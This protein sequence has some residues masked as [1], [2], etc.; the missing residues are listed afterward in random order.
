MQEQPKK[1]QRLLNPKK[2]NLYSKLYSKLQSKDIHKMQ[3]Y[4]NYL[5]KKRD[6][7]WNSHY[8]K[9]SI[10]TCVLYLTVVDPLD[11]KKNLI[12]TDRQNFPSEST[13]ELYESLFKS[14][15]NYNN[16]N[17]S[18]EL[19]LF[20]EDIEEKLFRHKSLFLLKKI[21]K[22]CDLKKERENIVWKLDQ[23]KKAKEEIEQA[24]SYLIG[25]FPLKIGKLS[26]FIKNCEVYI[27]AVNDR[28][29]KI[30]PSLEMLKQ[31]IKISMKIERLKIYIMIA[32]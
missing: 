24:K 29:N 9:E 14:D 7:L 27:K 1:Y 28:L 4:R 12:K 30:E 6:L 3:L 31:S 25:N 18:I 10:K 20:L 16:T 32:K 8:F 15:F 5:I 23:V 11:W 19:E 2:A 13:V 17:F 26:E 22:D 21:V